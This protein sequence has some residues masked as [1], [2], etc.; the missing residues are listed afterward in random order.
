MVEKSIVLGADFRYVTQITTTIKSIVYHNNHCKIYLMHSDIPVEWFLNL[1]Q[2]L[3]VLNCEVQGL[4]IENT[5]IKGY[6]TWHHISHATFFRYFIPKYIASNR[7]LYLDCDLIVTGNLDDFYNL[8]LGDNYVAAVE[9]SI[10]RAFYC[11]SEFNAGVLLI[12][13]RLWREDKIMQKA[14]VLNQKYDKILNDADQSV[15]NIL[16]EKRWLPLSSNYNFLTGFQYLLAKDYK[17]SQELAEANHKPAQKPLIIHYNTVGKPWTPEI[18]LQYREDWWFYHNLCWE[19]IY[20][21][22]LA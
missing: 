14:L 12:N 10:A 1:N 19:A 15:L 20:Q 22:H 7:V 4:G 9:D 17:Y 18:D 11:R 5:P 3:K 21:H 13:N 8:D 16:F 2:K 6:K